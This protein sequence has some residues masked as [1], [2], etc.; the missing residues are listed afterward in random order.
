M[1]IPPE[2]GLSPFATAVVSLLTAATAALGPAAADP[3]VAAAPPGASEPAAAAGV[4]EP[5]PSAWVPPLDGL[6]LVLEPFDPPTEDWLP[7]HRGVDLAAAVGS[8]VRSA[9]GGIVVWAAPV[10]GRGVVSV[11]HDD[12]RRTTYE[13][14]DPEVSIGDVVGRGQLLGTVAPGVGHCGGTPTCLHWGLLL[15]DEY[16]D[17]L[18]LLGAGR[19][20]LLPPEEWRVWSARR[21]PVPEP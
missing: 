3:P 13:P 16:L 7:G 18:S 20:V 2:A 21:V 11:L 17:P 19:P 5:A 1:L 15:G 8:E 6:L 12:G 9:G 10:A 4:P 14:V